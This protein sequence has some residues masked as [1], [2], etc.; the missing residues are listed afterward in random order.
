MR[1]YHVRFAETAYADLDSIDDLITE[2]AGSEVALRFIDRIEAYCLSFATFPQR[3]ELLSGSNTGIRKIG[4]ER[5]VTILFSV[6]DNT[7]T[8]LRVL[9]GGQNWRQAARR[10][11]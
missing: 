10:L 9:Y 7:V 5:R 4:F 11:R 8:V 3:G 1:H 2:F 6:T